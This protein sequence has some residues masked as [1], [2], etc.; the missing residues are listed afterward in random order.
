MDKLSSKRLQADI[1][2]IDGAADRFEE[3]ENE[4]CGNKHFEEFIIKVMQE[5]GYY[6]EDCTFLG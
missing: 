1:L 4:L 2:R 6:D 3:L 5:L